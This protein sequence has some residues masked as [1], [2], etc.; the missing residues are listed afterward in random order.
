M[1]IDALFP[2][3]CPV[4]GDIVMPK[5]SL[6]C[7]PCV[8]RLSFVKGPVCQR[9]GKEIMS[10]TQEYCADCARRKRSFEYGAALLNYN[11]TASRSMAA[12]KYK[13]K[14]EYLDYYAQESVRR[15]GPLLRSMKAGALIPVPIHPKRLRT[16]GFNQAEVLARKLGE[17]L[18]LPVCAGIL[19][20]SRNTEPQKELRASERLRNLEKAFCVRGECELP[21]SAILIDDIYTT[22]STIGA[23][24][25][26]LKKA[27]MERVYFFAL[28]IGQGE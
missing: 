10:D 4:C 25:R 8:P 24:A 17:A 22:G 15:C 12:V 14:R 28:C 26:A 21:H 3:R 6:I 5:G 23:G 1:L 2:R 19:E 11:E 7:P 9:C 20:R 18:S 27:G 13:N 16:R